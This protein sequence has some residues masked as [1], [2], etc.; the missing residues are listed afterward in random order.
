[1]QT[2]LDYITQTAS[3]AK[4]LFAGVDEYIQILRDAPVPCLVTNHEQSEELLENWAIA[5]R[6]RIQQSIEAQREFF[7]EKHAL[8][9]LCG[10]ILQIASMAIRLYS[11][12]AYVPP[13]FAACIGR[14][15]NARRHCIGRRVR[16]VP[17]GLIIYAGRNYYN[18]FEEDVLREPNLTVFEKM[19]TN[20]DYGIGIRDPAFDLGKEIGWNI[21]S[22]V[23]SILG[24]CAYE[25]YNKDMLR[26]LAI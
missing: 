21:P 2:V 24:W 26:L 7:A 10:S 9:T 17:I 5:N 25:P 19:A 14:N 20:H 1:M 16:D 23:T 22:N 12:N 4:H 8:A 6:E 11:K 3:A 13:E 18:H 15:D